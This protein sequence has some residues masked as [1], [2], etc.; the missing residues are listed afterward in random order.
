MST[1]K[2][3]SILARIRALRAKAANSASSEAEAQAAASRA[4]KL[5]VEYDLAESELGSDQE[6]DGVEYAT[7]SH[8]KTLHP[9]HQGVAA[10]IAKLTETHCWSENGNLR[11]AGM[12]ADLE[13]AVY[14][15]EMLRGA[16]ER[17]W[18]TSYMDQPMK[19][20]MEVGR[21]RAGFYVGFASRVSERI[22]DLARE[23]ETARTTAT[24]TDLMVIK[25]SLIM[26]KLREDGLSFRK[27]RN[28][29]RAG[30]DAGQMAGA[31]AGAKVGLGRPVSTTTSGMRQIA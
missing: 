29:S 21:F 27:G 18:M 28:R 26:R 20:R 11:F 15:S 22:F 17:G 8:D 24:G 31:A 6:R 25:R 2:L 1:D 12:P 19:G 30:S 9:V 5:M 10:A 7:A 14:L 3:K 23:R 4:A 16:A 13:M